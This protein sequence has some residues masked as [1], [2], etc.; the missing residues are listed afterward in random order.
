MREKSDIAYNWVIDRKGRIYE[1]RLWFVMAAAMCPSEESLKQVEDFGELVNPEMSPNYG[2]LNVCLFG[3]FTKQRPT[4]EQRSSLYWLSRMVAREF[5]NVFRERIIG[6]R[7]G[8]LIG[9]ERGV[10]VTDSCETRCPGEIEDVIAMAQAHF[11]LERQV[12]KEPGN[13]RKYEIYTDF[14]ERSIS[15]YG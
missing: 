9:E 6:H 10:E 15:V 2:V 4:P 7:D 8:Y 12:Y 11:G 13:K 1:G 5:P 3:D 14:R